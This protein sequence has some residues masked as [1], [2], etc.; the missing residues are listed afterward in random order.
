MTQLKT[1]FLYIHIFL[2]YIVLGCHV[3]Q[4]KS[5]ETIIT[6]PSFVNFKPSNSPVVLCMATDPDGLTWMGTDKGLIAFDGYRDYA[7]FTGTDLQTRINAVLLAGDTILIG[8][9]GGLRVATRRT[10][11]MLPPS[12]GVRCVRA[13]LQKGS[14]IVVG[15]A[16][17]VDLYDMQTGKSQVLARRLPQVYSL[18]DTP[19]GL[20]VGTLNGLYIIR[21][22]RVRAVNIGKL[23]QR[24][25]IN[26]MIHAKGKNCW[27]GTEGALFLY[28]GRSLKEV[29]ALHSNSIKALCQVNRTLYIGTDNGLYM[30]SDGQNAV[31]ISQD[32]RITNSLAS[33]IVWALAKDQWNNLLVGTDRGLS[34][35]RAHEPFHSWS[36]SAITGRGDG[37]MFGTLLIDADGTT[38]WAG[39]DNGLISMQYSA[40]G[41]KASKWYRQGDPQWSISHNRIRK[42]HRLS[43][44]TVI[45]C[46]DHGLYIIDS[47]SSMPRNVLLTDGTGHYNATWAYDIVEDRKGRCWVAAYA[48]G[49]FIIDSKRLLASQGYVKADVHLGSTLIGVNVSSLAIDNRGRVWA[50]SYSAGIDCIDVTSFH[51]SHVMNETSIDKV[52]ADAG[53][54]VWA[55]MAGKVVRF[56]NGELNNQHIFAMVDHSMTPVALG[57]ADNELWITANNDVCILRPNGTS[58]AFSLSGLNAFSMVSQMSWTNLDGKLCKGV[59]L[60]GEDAL[61]TVSTNDLTST[62]HAKLKLTGIEVNGRLMCINDARIYLGAKGKLTFRSNENNFKLLFSDNP[63]SGQLPARYAYRMEGVGDRW[64][65]L[66]SERLQVSFNGLPHGTYR[67]YV[68]IVD[69]QGQPSKIIYEL[70]VTVLPPWYLT[71]WAKAIYLLLFLALVA[72][73]VRFVWMRRELRRER[74]ARNDAME[75]S[76]R[77]AEFFAS[78]SEKLKMSAGSVLASSCNLR[79]QL[80]GKYEEDINMIRHNG[81]AICLMASEAL[82]LPLAMSNSS[83]KPVMRQL[84]LT[85][86]CQLVVADS[87]EQGCGIRMSFSANI[88]ALMMDMDVVAMLGLLNAIMKFVDDDTLVQG[89]AVLYAEETDGRAVLRLDVEQITLTPEKLRYA[90]RSYSEHSLALINER[91]R[92]MGAAVSFDEAESGH[93]VIIIRTGYKVKSQVLSTAHSELSKELIANIENTEDDQSKSSADT[94]KPFDVND[95]DAVMKEVTKIIEEHLADPDLN[96]QLLTKLTGYGTKLIYRRMKAVTG[97][98]PVNYIRQMRMLRAAVLLKQGRFAVS[99]VMYMVGFSTQSYFSKCF[100]QTY[101]ISPTEYSRR[102]S[103]TETIGA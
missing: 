34:V 32:I 80:H 87:H 54:S 84:D 56:N 99:E 38:L 13:L 93:I 91:A 37:N 23:A 50:A 5:S 36:L 12:G 64:T 18:L 81:A 20:F 1:Y 46:T 7:L 60:S 103:Q 17:G 78:L 97:Y 88:P 70:M 101:G 72:W 66:S 59:M 27:I 77:R 89:N 22:G 19:D 26:A 4:A 2:I 49:I 44:G 100:S 31:R 58:S 69:G 3:L 76:A 28:N 30:L 40:D 16:D 8:T 95:E 21:N 43:D 39:G 94:F 45:A 15:G 25:L 51:V 92:K 55:T 53:G 14:K 57:T 79:S 75:Q 24:P 67:L 68:S 86:L 9:D 33:N 62:N 47:Q 102:N 42:L 61:M 82:D 35:H 11:R 73:G 52:V 71:W 6:Q 74:Q 41:W 98:T 90:F 85:E 29:P 83:A 63:Q 65:L 48:G 10:L 96:V